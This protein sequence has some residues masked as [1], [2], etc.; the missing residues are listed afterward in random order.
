MESR[1]HRLVTRRREFYSYVQSTG[2]TYEVVKADTHVCTLDILK[3]RF[4]LKECLINS[5]FSGCPLQWLHCMFCTVMSSTGA[6][7]RYLTLQYLVLKYGY[8]V[9]GM[10]L[11]LD[12][13]IELFCSVT[14][15]TSA[16][17][18]SQELAGTPA[19]PRLPRVRK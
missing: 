9:P 18:V 12:D 15:I 8:L 19:V 3:T 10:Y 4:A 6:V 5:K 2:Y 16:F 17:I 13:V 7:N 1:S 11:P 14:E